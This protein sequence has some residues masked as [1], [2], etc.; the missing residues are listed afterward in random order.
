M[1]IYDALAGWYVDTV[2]AVWAAFVGI[3][4]LYPVFTVSVGLL[5]VGFA[6]YAGRRQHDTF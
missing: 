6:V 3:A 5:V 2:R 4:A 1:N